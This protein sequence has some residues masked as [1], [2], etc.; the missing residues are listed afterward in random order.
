VPDGLTP[1]QLLRVVS[2]LVPTDHVG[3]LLR[4]LPAKMFDAELQLYR[5]I[6][7]AVLAALDLMEPCHADGCECDARLADVVELAAA[8]PDGA[9][10]AWTLLPDASPLYVGK[11]LAVV[12]QRLAGLYAATKPRRTSKKPATTR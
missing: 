9:R 8:D 4:R 7:P 3:E 2:D 5:P 12:A 10:D 11:L 6:A 1:D